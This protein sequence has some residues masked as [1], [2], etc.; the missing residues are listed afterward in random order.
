V[1]V[2]G[3][4]FEATMRVLIKRDGVE[5]YNKPVMLDR[6]APEQ[7]SASFTVTLQPGKYTILGYEV[8][9]KDGSVQHLD[10]HEFT[11]R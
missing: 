9:L 10:D 7:G 6:G 1:N 4:V 2:S 8:S 3:I 11:V 5:V